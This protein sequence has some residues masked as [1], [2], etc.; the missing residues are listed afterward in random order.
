MKHK[1]LQKD[2][3]YFIPSINLSFFSS[4]FLPSLFLLPLFLPLPPF[5]P[6]ICSLWTLTQLSPGPARSWGTGNAGMD[7]TDNFPV[8]RA[9]CLVGTGAGRVERGIMTNVAYSAKW[10]Y[11]VV[12]AAW[13]G[14][15]TVWVLVVREGFLEE[16]S[17]YRVSH[18]EC[19]DGGRE[20]WRRKGTEKGD[21]R[22]LSHSPMPS[23]LWQ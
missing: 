14:C 17:G 11:R 22:H 10:K 7:K 23:P 6:S 15:L 13:A 18:T 12:I 1:W 19:V 2:S 3:V 16:E 9:Y 21:N 8:L 5:T 4:F 20:G